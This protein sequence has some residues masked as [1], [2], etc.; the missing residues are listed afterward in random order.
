MSQTA[1]MI[2]LASFIYTSLNHGGNFSAIA[3]HARVRKI[4]GFKTNPN[5]LNSDKKTTHTRGTKIHHMNN[6]I[7]GTKIG[8]ME[9]DSNSQGK[10][11]IARNFFFGNN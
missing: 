7:H 1:S 8:N 5:T 11:K 10:R 2:T 9:V 4:A 3:W 6:R